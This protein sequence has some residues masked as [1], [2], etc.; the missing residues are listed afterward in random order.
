MVASTDNSANREAVRLIEV[1]E[2]KVSF[3]RTLNRMVAVDDVSF[4]IAPGEVLGI[5][6]ESGCGKTTLARSIIGLSRSDPHC[7]VSGSV[8]FKGR[9]LLRLDDHRMRKL[10]GAEISMVFQDPLTSLNPLQRVG[11][12]IQEVLRTHTDLST[13]A[14]RARAIELLRLVGMPHPDDRI[15]AYP[16]QISGGMRQRVMIAIAIACNPSLLIADEP[17]TALDVTTQLQI[18]N[19]L[20]ELRDQTGM[21]VMLITHDFGVVAKVADK[22]LVMYSGQCVEAGR[23]RDIFGNPQHPYTAGLLA[24]IP[25]VDRP[26]SVRL[27]AIKGSPPSLMQYRTPGCRFM[28]RCNLR[29]ERCL[30]APALE[31]LEENS[32]HLARC[33]LAHRDR[34]LR[35]V[36]SIEKRTDS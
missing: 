25:S 6:G 32:D 1:R 11:T 26:R 18:L 4:E 33:W 7:H 14:M 27:P 36:E 10:R 5:V 3:G 29:Q 8:L 23:V 35:R 2:L 9:E 19:L 28:A 15:D 24:S 16:H 31:R 30:E 22:V 34:A 21:A 17:T 20:A 12:Q 13:S